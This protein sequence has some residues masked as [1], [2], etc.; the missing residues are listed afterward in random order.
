MSSPE[1]ARWQRVKTIFLRALD[2]A[3]PERSAFLTDACAGDAELHAEVVSLLASDQR[4]SSFAETPAAEVLAGG[5]MP[6]AAPA[7]RLEPGARLGAYEVTAFL[8]AGG[9]GEVYRARHTVLGR[10]VAIKTL[11]AQPSDGLAKRRLIR[12]AQHAANLKHQNI[13]TIHEVGV[14]DETPFIV[15]EYLEGRPL[16]AIVGEGVPPLDDALAWG[17]QVADALEH[18]H[19]HGIVHRDLKSSNVVIDGAGRAIVLDFGLAKRIADAA[20]G[21]PGEST[22]ILDSA[23]AGTLT[24][25]APEALIGGHTDARTD[26]W[27]LGVLLYELTTGALPF[28][29]RTPFETSSAILSEPPRAIGRGVPLALRLVIER[30]L[31]KDPE[32]RYGRAAEVRTA[33]DAIR[34]RK[35][36]PIVGRLLVAARRRTLYATGAVITIALPLLIGGERLLERTGAFRGPTVSTLALLPIENA[37]G[38]SAAAYYAHGLTEALIAQLGSMADVRIISRGSAERVARSAATHAEAARQLGADAIIVGRLRQASDRIA[39]DLRVIE[40]A[41]GRVLWSDRYERAAGHVLA[42]QADAVAALARTIRLT[43]RSD[44]RD[45]LGTVR[46]VNPDAYQEYLKGRYAWNQRTSASLQQAVTHF[47]N[48]I[49]LDPTYAP[50]HTALADCYNQF[51]TLMLGTGSPRE[52]RPRAAAAVVRALQIDPFSADAHATLGYVRHYD[53]Q[54]EEAER[55]FRRAIEMNPSHALARI[56]Y[57]NLLMSRGRIDEAITQVY[58]ARELD[59]FSLIINSNVG[60]VLNVAERYDDAIAQMTQTLALDSTYVQAHWR[61]ADALRGAGRYEEAYEHA[62]HAIALAGRTPPA[63]ANLAHSAALLGRHDEVHALLTEL[64]EQARN[65]YVAPGTMADMLA[66]VGDMDGA[67]A[68][69]ARALE[70]R[71]NWAVYQSGGTPGPLQLDPRFREMFIRAGVWR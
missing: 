60:W 30:C 68:W 11:C 48:A 42:L 35:A 53:W 18:A 4:A 59:P 23:V 67:L 3:E 52:F 49:E 58:T 33:L 7:P 13:C 47:T 6:D 28:H 34:R 15:M 26:V 32:G 10:T 27:S 66:L 16:R 14:Q 44:A 62:Q 63:I 39:L 45:R 19:Q 17:I 70:E 54:F 21:A 51:G 37:T 2:H 41:R 61:M 64:R 36:W 20:G 43:I 57:A 69:T 56:W 1:A 50:A 8:S 29:G 40:P 31:A 38:D 12:E 65:G 71:A 9:M 5:G 55:E 24:H 46:A 22:V 25:M